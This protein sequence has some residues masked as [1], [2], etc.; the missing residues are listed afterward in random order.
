MQ[1]LQ[2]HTDAAIVWLEKANSENARLTWVH[3]YLAAAYALK[4]ET[5]RAHGALAEA[6]RLSNTYSS[7]T[8]VAKSNWYDNPQIRA[9]AEA[10]YFKGL[11]LAGISEE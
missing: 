11:R 6:Q 8:S 1:L 4:G 7:L 5:D 2:S 10:T 9:L 3:S